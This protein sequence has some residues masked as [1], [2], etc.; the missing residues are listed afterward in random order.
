MYQL[1][2]EKLGIPTVTIVTTNFASLAEA[3]AKA[4]GA[5]M[6][7]VV[8]PHPMG[9]ISPET[10][11]EKADAAFTKIIEAATTWEA[12]GKFPAN[13]EQPPS[14]EIIRLAGTDADVNRVFFERGWAFGLP[15]L[16][17]RRQ[18]VEAML[19]ETERS[20]DEVLWKVPPRNAAL[21][22]KVLAAN[23]VMAGCKPEYMP[24]LISIVSAMKEPSFDWDT[25][26]VT[27]NPIFPLIIVNGPIAQKLGIASGQGAARGG[28]H[29]NVSIGYFVSLI[30]V[31][32]GSKAP[33]LDRTTLGQP[34]NT[35]AIVIAENTDAL[36]LSWKPLN[37]EMG[38]PPGT[39]T[40]TLVGVEGNRNMNIPE[41]DNAEGIL[42]VV[43]SE[44]ETLGAN[45]SVMRKGEGLDTV[46]LLCPQ[47]AAT[48]EKDGWSKQDV[49]KYLFQNARIPYEK[50][51]LNVTS[52]HLAMPWYQQWGPGDTVP[53][54]D[55]P[56]N[57]IVVVAGGAGTHSQ[58]L[59][60]FRKSVTRVV[61]Q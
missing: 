43:A 11:R 13:K 21:T 15:I 57:I 7:F 41:Q 59:S 4:R 5:D 35:V 51:V 61:G 25:Q 3:T 1:E 34:G 44:M 46:L 29:A 50:W 56:D 39:S 17:P 45:I 54:L 12:G 2:I 10:V 19:R 36:P 42:E 40:V 52:A 60:G 23:A 58:Y 6:P 28:Y 48:K 14:A 53:V 32:G 38:Y 20:P 30:G 27:T 33:E 18:R 8:V 16:P 55:T 24:L 31:V 37:A 22:V 26:A 47:H 9:G 49:K